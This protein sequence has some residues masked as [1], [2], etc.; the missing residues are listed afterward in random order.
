MEK[1][2]QYQSLYEKDYYLWLQKT[3]EILQTRQLNQLD[4]DNLKS[5]I[6]NLKTHV[7]E[8]LQS[9]LITLIKNLL[10]LKY[11]TSEKEYNARGWLNNVIEQRL[12]IE[13]SLEDSPSLRTLLDEIFFDC[14]EQART[15]A[16]K[17]HQLPRD[18]FPLETPFSLEDILN[19]DYLP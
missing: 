15:D 6:E 5:E 11:W 12:K 16:L 1:L 8:T 18:L 3:S 13:L 19:S 4:I 2:S 10:K 17:T 7:K 14:Y 9:R